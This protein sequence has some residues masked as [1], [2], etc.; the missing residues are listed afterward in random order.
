MT[1][2]IKIGWVISLTVASL[3]WGQASIAC[4]PAQDGKACDQSA[5]TGCDK[6]HGTALQPHETTA[7]ADLQIDPRRIIHNVDGLM[8]GPGDRPLGELVPSP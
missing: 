1:R 2:H 3:S 4:E 7:Q 6:N 8:Y 5:V